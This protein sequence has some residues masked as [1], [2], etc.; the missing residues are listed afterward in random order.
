VVNLG[1]TFDLVNYAHPI[2]EQF[3]ASAKDDLAAKNVTSLVMEVPTTCLTNPG[4]PVLGAWTTFLHRDDETE[5][6]GDQSAGL[7]SRQSA[8]Q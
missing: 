2:G 3:A 4:N 5:R 6:T 1:E 8:G 7:P